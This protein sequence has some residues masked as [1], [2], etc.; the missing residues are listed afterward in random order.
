MPEDNS[1]IYQENT[2]NGDACPSFDAFEHGPPD[3][4]RQNAT[5]APGTVRRRDLRV[6]LT[7]VIWCLTDYVLQICVQSEPRK[8]FPMLLT[9]LFTHRTPPAPTG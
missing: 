1:R 3:V 2:V 4:R 5:A 6:A 7:D 9:A 8:N